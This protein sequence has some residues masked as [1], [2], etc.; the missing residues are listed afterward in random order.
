MRI[1]KI[2]VL[3]PQPNPFSWCHD[4]LGEVLDCYWFAPWGCWRIQDWTGRWD[5]TFREGYEAFAIL[6]QSE[7]PDPVISKTSPPATEEGLY[8]PCLMDGRT[9]HLSKRLA[10]AMTRDRAEHYL[11]QHYLDLWLNA[12]AIPQPGNHP[13]FAQKL[14]R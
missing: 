13:Y 11:K 10:P 3:H 1:A 5:C 8:Y 2:K 9:G 6:E 4:H 12:Q 7:V 14:T